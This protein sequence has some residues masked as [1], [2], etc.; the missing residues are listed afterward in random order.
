[1]TLTNMGGSDRVSGTRLWQYYSRSIDEFKGAVAFDETVRDYAAAVTKECANGDVS[2]AAVELYDNVTST[3][4]Y[5]PS[6]TPSRHIQSPKKTIYVQGGRVRRPECAP[7]LFT[8]EQR[9]QGV[10]HED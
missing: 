3:F 5:Y 2:C 6:D 4:G 8:R 10:H 7:C 9:G 1:M